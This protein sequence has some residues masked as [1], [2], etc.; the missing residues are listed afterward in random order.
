MSAGEER[1]PDRWPALTSAPGHCAL[2]KGTGQV[3][4]EPAIDACPGCAELAHQQWLARGAP[5]ASPHPS[6]QSGP[7]HAADVPHR[8]IAVTRNHSA[9]P[10]AR[11]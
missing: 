2:C 11:P 4:R 5:D 3:G 10:G 9:K 8:S 7:C 6:D 1:R